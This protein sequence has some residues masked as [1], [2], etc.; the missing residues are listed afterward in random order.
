MLTGEDFE[1]LKFVAAT[2]LLRVGLLDYDEREKFEVFW[3]RFEQNVKTVYF[4]RSALNRLKKKP[5]NW[6]LVG[7]SIITFLLGFVF[8]IAVLRLF[9]R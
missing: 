9:L 5:N 8:Q 6:L 1:Q 7:A 2:Q 3:M 4:N